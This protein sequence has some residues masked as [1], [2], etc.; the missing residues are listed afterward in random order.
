MTERLC[1]PQSDT[2]F[3][4]KQQRLAKIGSIFIIVVVFLNFTIHGKITQSVALLNCPELS[5]RISIV[6]FRRSLVKKLTI[7]GNELRR[8]ALR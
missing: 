2:K 4:S 7:D 8:L 6:V 3:Y 1:F 5:L